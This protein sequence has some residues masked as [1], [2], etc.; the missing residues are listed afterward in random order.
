M[1]IPDN[2]V[3]VKNGTVFVNGTE[4]PN[5]NVIVIPGSLSDKN[6]LNFTWDLVSYTAQE[7]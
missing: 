1:N 5:L 6:M 7:L 4:L 2:V 3:E